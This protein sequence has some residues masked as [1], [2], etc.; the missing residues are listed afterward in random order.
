MRLT[1]TQLIHRRHVAQILP[2][3]DAV[4]RAFLFRAD[5]AARGVC[6][7]TIIVIKDKGSPRGRRV[8]FKV[9]ELAEAWNLHARHIMVPAEFYEFALSGADETKEPYSKWDAHRQQN[10][11]ATAVFIR[12]AREELSPDGATL[13]YETNLNVRVEKTPEEDPIEVERRRQ[14]AFFG[15]SAHDYSNGSAKWDPDGRN[16]KD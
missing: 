15:T 7:I 3:D 9:K 13:K 5:A 10:L 4:E 16:K 8:E 11:R 1:R 12:A 6:E 2:C 14:M